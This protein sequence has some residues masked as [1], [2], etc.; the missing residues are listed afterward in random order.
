MG[1]RALGVALTTAALFASGCAEAADAGEKTIVID[2]NHSTF[3]PGSL[4]VQEGDIV[5]FVVHNNDPID[6]ELIIGDEAVQRAHEEGTEAHHG[7]KPG[8]VSIPA[9]TTRETTYT[10]STSASLIY[11]CHLPR[12]YDYGMRGVISVQA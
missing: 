12:H 8:E 10:F 6:H 11:G 9:G 2:I 3:D 5:R 7:D 4:T 1:L